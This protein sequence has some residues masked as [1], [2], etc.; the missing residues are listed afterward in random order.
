MGQLLTDRETDGQVSD[1][2]SSP[3]APKDR[4]IVSV[5]IRPACRYSTQQ[6][7]GVIC[8]KWDT[9]DKNGQVSQIPLM[10]ILEKRVTIGNKSSEWKVLGRVQNDFVNLTNNFKNGQ[11]NPDAMWQLR[12][13][14]VTSEGVASTPATAKPFSTLPIG[15]VPKQP[16]KVYLVEQHEEHNKIQATIGWIPSADAGCQYRIHLFSNGEAGY[17]TQEKEMLPKTLHRFK[18]LMFSTNYT[19]KVRATDGAFQR[20][21]NATTFSFISMS[22][23]QA[24][25]GS[26]KKCAPGPPQNP[27]WKYEEN[28]VTNR[29]GEQNIIYNVN[30]QWD[31]PNGT[32]PS[33]NIDSYE[34]KWRKVP[35]F[36]IQ[37]GNNAKPEG[38]SIHLQQN[39]STWLF[40][41]LTWDNLYEIE[42]YAKSSAGI[43]DPVFLRINT[44]HDSAG[45]G[46]LKLPTETLSGF[47]W[48]KTALP[49][50]I[51]VLLVCLAIILVLVVLYFKRRRK[52]AWRTNEKYIFKSVELTNGENNNSDA[53]GA[54]V[55]E[56]E[57]SLSNL[58]LGCEI[59]E[60]AFGRVL[61]AELVTTHDISQTVAVKLLKPNCSEED[62]SALI[63]EIEFLKQLGPHINIVSIVACCTKGRKVCLVLDYCKYGDLRDYLKTLREQWVPLMNIVNNPCAWNSKAD[64]KES[65]D[66]DQTAI[67]TLTASTGDGTA[68]SAAKISTTKLLSYARQITMGM[69]FLA[70][71]KFVHRDLAARNVLVYDE[72]IVKISDFGLTRDVYENSIYKKTTPGKV[73]YKWMALES[74]F[75][76]V[77]TIK[78]DV[79]SFGIVLW[80]LVTLG[81][82]PYPGLS[83][84]DL[85]NFL[86]AGYRMERPDN[87]TNEIYDIMLI[88]W[89]PNPER[90]PSFTA[91]KEKIDILLQNNSN[92]IDFDLKGNVDYYRDSSQSGGTEGSADT[93]PAIHHTCPN[94][95]WEP[96]YNYNTNLGENTKDVTVSYS[97]V[98]HPSHNLHP[99]DNNIR[100]NAFNP[101]Q[102]DHKKSHTTNINYVTFHSLNDGEKVVEHQSEDN[103]DDEHIDGDLEWWDVGKQAESTV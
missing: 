43:S 13:T 87:C 35:L 31:P 79:W 73:P 52:Y 25:A 21:S 22:C 63:Q 81:G 26:F 17:I 16:L 36:H 54:C 32:S 23:L 66:S 29:T 86:K 83:G 84:I 28:K 102:W 8:W 101:D 59:G 99:M 103:D 74:I 15:W 71:K 5:S 69:E 44:T 46:A 49:Y 55:D 60:G 64:S 6:N 56:Y 88:C 77:Y 45:L 19:V 33:N 10:T 48:I 42:I 78:S 89:H 61:K 91:L 100:I 70:K 12:V 80:E 76:N 41:K 57:V 93:I 39:T 47:S 34:I 96:K 95:P 24:Y 85:F 51:A 67:S 65:T 98:R 27:Q 20:E 14:V 50:L 11:L 4:R 68:S 90:R 53:S 2:N 30:V 7:P 3:Y 92:Y 1:C 75:N 37:A 94:K 97:S 58:V 40:E 72:N 82:S 62:R 9:V 18:N 38:D